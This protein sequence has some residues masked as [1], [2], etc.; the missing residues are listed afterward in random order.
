MPFPPFARCW[1]NCY[2]C[3]FLYLQSEDVYPILPPQD[4]T[5]SVCCM[6]GRGLSFFLFSKPGVWHAWALVQIQHLIPWLN[7]N[8][9]YYYYL[10]HSYSTHP[11]RSLGQNTAF[12]LLHCILITALWDSFGWEKMT[13]PRLPSRFEPE[14][15]RFSFDTLATTPHT[16]G[17]YKDV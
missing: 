1:G 3:G 8:I 7:K 12:T 10:V 15:P 16:W 4:S 14:S 2:K 9:L 5:T 13:G 6:C 17:M 11:P